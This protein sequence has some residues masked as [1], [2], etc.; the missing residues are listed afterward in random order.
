MADALVRGG[1]TGGGDRARPGRAE[2]VAAEL[3]GGAAGFAL[4][5]R[6]PGVDRAGVD[7]VSIASAAST[8]SCA[9]RASASAR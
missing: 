8:C 7:A 4:D 5:V 6:D 9:T 3:G 1:R 2:A